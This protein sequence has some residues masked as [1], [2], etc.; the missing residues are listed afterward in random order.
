MSP[1]E[2]TVALITRW[3]N[4]MAAAAIIAV[5]VIVC[6]NVVGR[7]VFGSPLKGTV[8]IVSLLGA[9]IIAGAIAYTQVLKGHIRITLLVERLPNRPRYII[10]S[11][12]DLIGFALFALISWQTILFARD[13]YD[14]GEL[15]EVLKIPLTPFAVVITVGC[16]ALTLVLL[17]DLLT[18][19]SKAVKK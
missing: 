4:W 1:I 11:L 12:I 9:L 15:S 2:K 17:V 19:L 6:I 7:G 8:D 16:V 10:A 3:L 14:I 18:S 13:T 5:M